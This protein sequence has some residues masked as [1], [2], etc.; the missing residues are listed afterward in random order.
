MHVSITSS[1]LPTPSGPR[2]G[3][4]P[5]VRVCKFPLPPIGLPPTAMHMNVRL[6]YFIPT[7]GGRGGG[8]W[9]VI[10]RISITSNARGLPHSAFEGL[11]FPLRLKG[12]LP[13]AFEGPSSLCLRRALLPF[14]F[15]A[16]R[17]LRVFFP[18]PFNGSSSLCLRRGLRPS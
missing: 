1:Y 13:F 15:E 3:W 17:T 5:N 12:L 7:P 14:A 8:P 9:H 4:D 2:W 10:V 16:S 11:F 6:Y 18:L